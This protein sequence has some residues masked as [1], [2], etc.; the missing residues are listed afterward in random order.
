M[1]W[2]AHLRLAPKAPLLRVGN[3]CGDFVRGV[4][5]DSLHPEI[6]RGIAQH[7][8]IDRFVDAHAATRRSR[9]RLSPR[10]FA[11]VLVDVFYD[12]FLARD[13][14]ELGDGRPLPAFVDDV[15][16]LLEEHSGLL[17]PRLLGALPAMRTEGWLTSYA[18]LDGIDAILRRMG[19]RTRRRAELVGAGAALRAHYHDLEADFRDLWPELLAHAGR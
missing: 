2:L 6:R 12:H 10:R 13:W 18:R 8:A 16:A 4:E 9:A 5:P 11:A 1:N 7:R 17:P 14:P 19:A 3:L 15:H